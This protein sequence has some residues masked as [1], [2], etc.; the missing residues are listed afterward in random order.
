[1]VFNFLQ[2]ERFWKYH[3]V[4]FSSHGDARVRVRGT[5]LD[6]QM[7]MSAAIRVRVRPWHADDDDTGDEHPDPNPN[8]NPNPNLDKQMTMTA[9]ISTKLRRD[10]QTAC[11]YG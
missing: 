3:A 11:R 1:M 2:F 4:R 9:V 10:S 7:T 6:K 5:H 8:P